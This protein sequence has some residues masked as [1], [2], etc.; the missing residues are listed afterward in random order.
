MQVSPEPESRA[1]FPSRVTAIAIRGATEA[2]LMDNLR[3]ADFCYTQARTGSW[4]GAPAWNGLQDWGCP[5]GCL[6]RPHK[7]NPFAHKLFWCPYCGNSL[8]GQVRASWGHRHPST[9]GAFALCWVKHCPH[10]LKEGGL[11]H[12]MF[13]FLVSDAMCKLALSWHYKEIFILQNWL[14][15]LFFP[16][17]RAYPKTRDNVHTHR[18]EAQSSCWT[19]SWCRQQIH[20]GRKGNCWCL[21]GV[22]RMLW[23]MSHIFI[24]S[25]FLRIK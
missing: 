8:K 23:K 20:H 6:S 3:L 15:S 1:L 25:I 11:I 4:A 19:S 12:L 9:V 18:E 21:A 16:Q 22:G 7:R 2:A 5:E 17:P 24:F 10:G 13:S 14:P